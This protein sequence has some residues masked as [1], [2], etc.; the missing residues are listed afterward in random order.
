MSRT[1]YDCIWHFYTWFITLIFSSF[2][3]FVPFIAIILKQELV[4]RHDNMRFFLIFC[5]VCIN[6]LL[7]IRCQCGWAHIR[8]LNWIMS[9]NVVANGDHHHYKMSNGTYKKLRLIFVMAMN[10]ASIC[11]HCMRGLYRGKNHF[12]ESLVG[13]SWLCWSLG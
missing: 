7:Y 13:C 11:E 8:V 4:E 5:S 12:S 2:P 9:G 6:N 1:N 10:P 3:T